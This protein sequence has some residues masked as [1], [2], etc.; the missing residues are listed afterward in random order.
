MKTNYEENDE[1]TIDLAD[2]FSIIVKKLPIIIL[3]G[4]IC[5]LIALGITKTLIVPKY[6]AQTK[7]YVLSN[8]NND[9]GVTTGD[10][11][12]GNYLTK[13]YME[14]VK[15]KPVLEYAIK[16]VGLNI[17]PEALS[18]MISLE[19]PSD[20]RILCI[21]VTSEDPELASDIANAVREQAG[22]QICQIMK[23]DSVNVVEEAEVPTKP[24]SPS[25]AKNT[26]LGALLGIIIA[27]GI[28]VVKY[29]LDDTI[30]NVSDVEKYLGLTTL[31]SIPLMEGETKSKKKA[32][33]VK[34]VK[35]KASKNQN[36]S[37]GIK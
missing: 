12:V 16:K 33:K 29:L 15:S 27:G 9:S 31:T 2:L 28:V 5:A 18:K 17:T 36:R 21:K 8:S 32:K 6:V 3:T 1:I 26:V 4:I 34:K 35:S 24:S 11:Q 30:K 10:L 14:L 37:K 19:S 23:A 7:V 13:D 20:T 25:T 22:K